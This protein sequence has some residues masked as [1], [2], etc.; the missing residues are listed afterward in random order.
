ML[1]LFKIATAFPSP[2]RCLD[3]ANIAKSAFLRLELYLLANKASA[4]ARNICTVC[5]SSRRR[6]Q[7]WK[8][9]TDDTS[10][11]QIV[12]QLFIKSCLHRSNWIES[13]DPV[14]PS[15]RK[16]KAWGHAQSHVDLLSGV[17]MYSAN[18]YI[19][20]FVLIGYTHCSEIVRPHSSKQKIPVGCLHWSSRTGHCHWNTRVR[21]DFTDSVQFMWREWGF[22]D[23]SWRKESGQRAILSTTAGWL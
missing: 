21:N 8:L 6:H 9:V 11:T 16:R 3:V 17:P 5:T 2:N 13:V 22:K 1:S 18:C 23:L 20:N 4:F 10:M 19:H 15:S 12:V 14:T 7:Q